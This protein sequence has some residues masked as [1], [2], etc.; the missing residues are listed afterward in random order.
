MQSLE[1]EPQAGRFVVVYTTSDGAGRAAKANDLGSRAT[2]SSVGSVWARFDDRS[3]A[4]FAGGRGAA[5]PA[6]A[7]S[8]RGGNSGAQVARVV[9]VP[10]GDDLAAGD[11]ASA[12]ALWGERGRQQLAEQLAGAKRVAVA[13]GERLVLWPRIG[14]LVSDIPGVL[15]VIRGHEDLGVLF[16]PVALLAPDSARFAADFLKRAAEIVTHAAPGIDAIYVPHT[17]P[18]GTDAAWLEPVIAA[19]IEARVPVCRGPRMGA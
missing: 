18:A 11:I 4:A 8:A 3:L 13:T 9:V 10:R 19:A 12:F 1:F 17:M 15:N 7:A 6:R 5:D 2:G 14:T 16:D